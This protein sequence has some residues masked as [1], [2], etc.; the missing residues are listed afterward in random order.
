VK[1]VHLSEL[2]TS[3][4]SGHWGVDKGTAEEDVQVIR[5]GDIL[6][7]GDI[8]WE[9]LPMR[10]FTK[11]EVEKSKLVAGDI[12]LTTSGDCGHVAHID[13]QPK[14]TT[15]ATNFV[16]ALRLDQDK[17]LPRYL[18]HLMNREAYRLSLAPF[19]RGT[20]LQNLSTTAAIEKSKILLP[21]MEEQKRI[22]AMLDKADELRRKRRESISTLDSLA[23]SIF[24]DLFDSPG[25]KKWPSTTVG[26]LVAEGKG[27]IRTGPFGSQLLHSEFVDEG[28]A[29]LGIDN[30]VQNRFCWAKPRFITEEK[31]E[32]LTRY[33]VRPR[34][35]IITIMGTCGRCAII[36]ED[37]PTAINT[38][39]LCCITLN[40]KKC[41]PEFLHAY[42]LMHPIAQRYLL[43]KAKGAIMNGLN[44]G[45]IKELPVPET[46]M[47]LQQRFKTVSE[48]IELQRTKLLAAQTE[49]ENLFTALQQKAFSHEN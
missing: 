33:T 35:V 12:V 5:N 19:I 1:Q 11:H 9:K 26:H 31:Y 21:S 40:Q 45:I 18:F 29:V 20:T 22:A 30:A 7:S 36:P 44:M 4:K 47:E 16:R 8:R 32:K 38:K 3:F 28:I 23:Q 24:L 39:H 10:G 42:F 48:K 34:D 49:T 6:S 41:Q 46:P 27:K 14:Q 25:S 43:Q 37:I 15:C 13:K 2:V 17:V